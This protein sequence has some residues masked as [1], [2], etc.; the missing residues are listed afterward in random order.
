MGSDILQVYKALLEPVNIK[1]IFKI[2]TTLSDEIIGMIFK[3]VL[4]EEG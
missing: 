1:A 3:L 2:S 4:K